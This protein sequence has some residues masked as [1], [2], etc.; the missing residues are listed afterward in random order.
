MRN[1]L[2]TNTFRT[3]KKSFTRF[4]SLFIMS[5]LGVF[6]F[7]GLLATSPD[8]I[9]TLDNYF[10]KNDVYDIKIIST[11]GLTDKDI[12]YLKDIP[13]ILDVEGCYSKDVFIKEK[14]FVI[15][16]EFPV[17]KV[18]MLIF[19]LIG[20]IL[21]IKGI[22]EYQNIEYCTADDCG[23]KSLFLAGVGIILIISASVAL[24][25]DE[26]KLKKA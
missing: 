11:F 6:V 1:R 19:I 4:L 2:F 21:T 24:V 10:D 13:S 7:S 9:K 8:M 16:Q 12:A 26:V 22:V 25:R 14:E 17:G 18:F 15:K 5:M 23:F 20:I 3:I